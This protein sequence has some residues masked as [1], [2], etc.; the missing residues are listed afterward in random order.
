MKL[1]G[2][3]GPLRAQVVYLI[4]I[5]VFVLQEPVHLVYVVS[6]YAF[7]LLRR[8]THRY[9]P[10]CDI[11]IQVMLRKFLAEGIVS[12]DQNSWSKVYTNKNF[13]VFESSQQ[14]RVHRMYDYIIKIN[15]KLNIQH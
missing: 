5:L 10:V 13:K 9:Q 3:V 8:E 14:S 2:I 4:V 15:K 11:W 1:A 12:C 7:Q 6:V